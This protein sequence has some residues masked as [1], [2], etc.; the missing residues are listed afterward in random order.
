MTCHDMAC[1]FPISCRNG[2]PVPVTCC[3]IQSSSYLRCHESSLSQCDGFR[4]GQSLSLIVAG[5]SALSY[6]V[7][8]I[9]SA[10]CCQDRVLTGSWARQLFCLRALGMQSLSCRSIILFQ[11]LG[12]YYLWLWFFLW[13]PYRALGHTSLFV[14]DQV[15]HRCLPLESYSTVLGAF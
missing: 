4:W 6:V 12:G 10:S 7:P 3:A 9:S 2:W 15:V 5:Y 8:S 13:N 1:P 11:G 14:N